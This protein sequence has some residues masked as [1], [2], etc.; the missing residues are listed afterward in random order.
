[1]QFIRQ[2]K[3]RLISFVLAVAML[4]SMLHSPMLEVFATEISGTTITED[5]GSI[6]VQ[7][8]VAD[9]ELN[10]QGWI[11]GL[12]KESPGNASID[13]NPSSSC[14][15]YFLNNDTTKEGNLT[16]IW[17]AN[18]TSQNGNK[19]LSEALAED[20]WHIVLG[21]KYTE[22]Q[23]GEIVEKCIY[24][25]GLE[26][27]IL[28]VE[29]VH[30]WK[31][32]IDN[33]S[34]DTIL[35]EC[36]NDG[37]TEDVSNAKLTLTV[38]NVE[39]TGEIYSGAAIT[40]S[41]TS[42]VGLDTPT[43]Y[44]TGVDV[45]YQKSN[46]A[47]TEVGRYIASITI[48]ESATIELE[49][50][51]DSVETKYSLT[52][53]DGNGSGK[54]SAGD[55][56]IISA[57]I[58]E[59]KEFDVWIGLDNVEIIAGNTDTEAVTIKMPE[60][61]LEV[62]A[63]YK[64]AV[65]IP[66][67]YNINITPTSNGSIE[68]NKVTAAA[69]TKIILV[70]TPDIG[71]V[72]DTLNITDTSSNIL[73]IDGDNSFTMPESDVSITATFRLE[74]QEPLPEDEYRVNIVTPANGTVSVD[75]T[76]AK[77]NDLITITTKPDSG[78]ATDT[79]TV[80]D[81]SS[82]PVSVQNGKFTMPASNVTVI[83]T[84]KQSTT[85]KPSYKVNLGKVE[86]G[87]LSVDK[88]TAKE[89][90]I[91]VITATPNNGYILST[92][93]VIDQAFQEVLVQDGK[94]TMP[95]KEV[96]VQAMFK[97][98][99]A[100]EHE[101][102]WETGWQTSSEYHWHNCKG[103]G[104]C[105]ITETSSKNSYG[106][107][108]YSSESD[109]D[110][111]T[112]GYVRTI[113]SE[114]E[115]ETEADKTESKESTTVEVN[116]TPT[117]DVKSVKLGNTSSELI[118]KLLTAEEK[119]KVNSGKKLKVWLEVTDGEANISDTD[120]KLTVDNL[121]G[122]RHGMY[123]D[124]KLIKQFSGENAI[125]ITDTNGPVKISFTVPKELL[126]EKDTTRKYNILRVHNGEVSILPCDF[127][128]STGKLTFETD[129]FSAYSLIYK[130][131][132]SGDTTQTTQTTQKTQKT[133]TNKNTGKDSIPKTGEEDLLALWVVITVI[134]GLI[135]MKN[136]KANINSSVTFEISRNTR[137][138]IGRNTNKAD[139]TVNLVENNMIRLDKLKHL[140][141]KP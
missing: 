4:M 59:G 10:M 77:V 56:V 109:I 88:S 86:N 122:L 107:H 43:I 103:S 124:I 90:E 47:P 23:E 72:L 121:G 9:N 58:P 2:N 79:I 66:D 16:L 97:E 138:D 13:V 44:Y 35:V 129:R 30:D 3:I 102:S 39:Y 27:N 91:V 70:I 93:K 60:S 55:E 140:K 85:E 73:T 115:K 36:L 80:V 112:C 67:S 5:N 51:I 100:A 120:K 49:F 81:G 69:G 25:I 74:K 132:V 98:K 7:F 53:V 68:T 76:F 52:V 127:D 34:L 21:P 131:K 28:P 92:L 19:T 116:P 128:S 71:Y 32:S 38:E 63:T 12:M 136:R 61:D 125:T 106:K 50:S 75:K 42:L 135:T 110:C 64:D 99:P 84:F 137:L 105:T 57:S 82:N 24:Y 26:S 118:S 14:D 94:F 119:A 17:D 108:T 6:T 33:N 96:L 62:T 89:G 113:Q 8:N 45:D 117:F 104:T 126:P 48:A 123:L 11:L 29:H 130:D 133:Q 87:K 41:L 54:Y 40:D 134:S 15:Y 65:V 141:P 1:M 31:Y 37:C 22:G 114:E 78:Y 18:T 95:A 83:V 20:D 111:N 46:I 139:K 101:H